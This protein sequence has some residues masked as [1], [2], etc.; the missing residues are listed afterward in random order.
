[1]V[2][3]LETLGKAIASFLDLLGW[4][5]SLAFHVLVHLPRARVDL[6]SIT[7]QMERVGVQSVFMVSVISAFTGMVMAVQTLDQFLKFGASGYI[8]GVIALSMIREM[9]P[10]L[11]GIV[12]A[13]RV[14]SS[15]A[16]EI[17]TM[18]VT[19]QLDALRAFGL[20]EY[21]FVGVPRILASLVMLPI[22]TI[23]S[24]TV[25]TF[26]G[27]LYVAFRGIHPLIFKDSI[28]LLVNVYDINGGLLKSLVYGFVISIVACACGFR[29]EGGAKGVGETTTL[30]VVWSN[31]LILILNYML[32][33]LLF[34]GRV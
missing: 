22:L 23:F 18:K 5:A 1:M 32:S 7:D 19:E 30:A 15:M 20:D 27:Y 25:G 4:I 34:G 16:A 13:G 2:K 11:T 24:M 17:G 29:A 14:G 28:K 10:V 26:G 3:W 31:M 9:S 21:V 8:G 6:R 33:T 12:V